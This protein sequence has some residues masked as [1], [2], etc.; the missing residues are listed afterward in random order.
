MV[1]D[2]SGHTRPKGWCPGRSWRVALIAT[3]GIVFAAC[4]PF[5]LTA[6]GVGASAGVQYTLTG[7]AYRTFAAPLP[8]VQ[9]ALLVALD[10]LGIMVR[11][12]EDI[13]NGQRLRARAADREIEIE[14]E[15]VSAKATRMR[16]IART[17]VLLD[18]ATATEIIVQTEKA[19]GG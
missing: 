11:S 16:C 8:Q 15:V 9:V 17:G 2:V 4:D 7:I 10:R 19:L 5:T 13:V 1:Q 18:R 3:A 14:L 6:L 12:R